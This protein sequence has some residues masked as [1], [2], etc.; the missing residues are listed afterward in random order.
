MLRAVTERPLGQTR[1]I[2]LMGGEQIGTLRRSG[3]EIE[4]GGVLSFLCWG[5]VVSVVLFGEARE[6][7]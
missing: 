1:S 2:F 3:S 6:M 7:C 4:V 5:M